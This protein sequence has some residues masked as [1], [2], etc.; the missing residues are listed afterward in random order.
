MRIIVI[1][2]YQSGNAEFLYY[3]TLGINFFI[4]IQVSP[5]VFVD[6]L[7]PTSHKICM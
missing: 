6:S 5:V 7:N 3:I 4:E 2:N 1:L